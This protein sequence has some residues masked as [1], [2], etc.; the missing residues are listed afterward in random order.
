MKILQ[1][2]FMFQVHTK[3]DLRFKPSEADWLHPDVREKMLELVCAMSIKCHFNKLKCSYRI[4]FTYINLCPQHGS[5]LS[6]EGY[7]IIRSDA[8]RSQQ[9]N[10][11]DCLQKLRNML[12]DSAVTMRQPSPETEERMRQRFLSAKRN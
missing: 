3:V 4:H 1:G 8:T 6:K 11:A 12:R 10:L 9:L 2:L 7:L 5:K